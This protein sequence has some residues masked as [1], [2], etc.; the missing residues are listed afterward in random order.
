MGGDPGDLAV[1]H[2]RLSPE[3]TE[4]YIRAAN[5][6]LEVALDL[7]AW[8]ADIS[9]ALATTGG[10]V[11]VLLRNAMH[12][13]LT[14]WSNRHFG[15]PR[16]YL[17]PG[18]LLQPRAME[19]I[20]AARMRVTRDG[21]QEAA[22]RVVA[23][24]SLGFWR[25]LLAGHYDRT[26]W[27]NCLFRAFPGQGR[28]RV[29]DAVQRLHHARNR[30]AHHEPMFNRP[31]AHLHQDALDVAGWICPITRSWIERHSRTAAVLLRRPRT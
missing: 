28:R 7:Y 22:G 13:Q 24:L 16:W 17:D 19:D 31:I 15:E 11:E 6:D 5:G 21:H 29:H 3:R 9:A 1:L 4:P 25:F 20:R 12:D 27:R 2:H 14:I 18:G 8:N 23:E 30:L 10:H 26:L